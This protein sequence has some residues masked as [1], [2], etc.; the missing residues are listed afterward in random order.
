MKYLGLPADPARLRRAIRFSSF[1]TLARQERERGFIE[2]SKS[3]EQFFR[4]GQVGDW[5]S[6]LTEAQVERVIENHRDVMRDFGYLSKD[7][8]ARS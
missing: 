7:G 6:A 5:R 8:K 2:Q 3:N 1:E 4:K